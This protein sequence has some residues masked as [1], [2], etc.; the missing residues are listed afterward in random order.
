M[1]STNLSEGD[2]IQRNGQTFSSRIL[3]NFVV[4]YCTWQN[5]MHGCDWLQ[6]SP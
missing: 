5:H 3:A 6:M 2:Q 4:F 1:Q